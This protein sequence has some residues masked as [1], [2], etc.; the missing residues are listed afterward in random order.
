MWIVRDLNEWMWD[1]VVDYPAMWIIW[2]GEW[3]VRRMMD[4]P[5]WMP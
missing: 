4:R 5:F 2:L 3:N 1:A